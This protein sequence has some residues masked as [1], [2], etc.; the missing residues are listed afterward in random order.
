MKYVNVRGTS[1]I[2]ESELSSSV[3]LP[4][5]AGAGIA[6]GTGGS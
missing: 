3:V 5:R 4:G 2:E 6:V 1:H